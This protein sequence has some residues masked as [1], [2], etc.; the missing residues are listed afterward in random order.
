MPVG[1]QRVIPVDVRVISATN[2]NLVKAVNEGRFRKDLYFRLNVLNLQIPPLRDRLED[3][4]ELFIYFLK[5][6]S[7][8]NILETMN[9]DSNLPEA[10]KRYMWPGNVRELEGFSERYVALEEEN[11][12][13]H[14]TFYGLLKK[15][16]TGTDCSR[17]KGSVNQVTIDLGNMLDM[18]K[19]ILTQASKIIRGNKGDMAKI[20]GISRTTLWKKLKDLELQLPDDDEQLH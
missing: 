15:L 6:L 20:L 14:S 19:Q 12:K 7:G 9:I 18:E 17:I 5:K 3:V 13:S 1:G 10:L 16:T 8:P 2:L 4:P 11:T